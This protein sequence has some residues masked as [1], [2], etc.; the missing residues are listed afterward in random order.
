MNNT[1]L[2]ICNLL[3][4]EKRQSELYVG[5]TK[6][7]WEY[8]IVPFTA[9]CTEALPLTLMDKTIC[10][11]LDLDG[12]TTFTRLGT[13]LGLNVE[14]APERGEYRDAAEVSLLDNAVK[15]LMEYNMVERDFTY[16]S[17]N[18][19]ISLTEIGMEYYH[20]GKKFRTSSAKTF[21]VYFDR[22]S[23]AHAKAKD[24]FLTVMGRPDRSIVPASFKEEKFLKT[25]IHEQLPAIYDPEKGNSFTN[26]SCPP[27]AE[28]VKVPVDIGVLYDVLTREYRYVAILDEKVN[29]TL[30]EII[31][32]N[33]QI[34]QE[35][36]IQMR[37]Q[38]KGTTQPDIPV[39]EDFETSVRETS[40]V[41][42]TGHSITK[43][44]PRVMETEEFWQGLGLLVGEKEESVFLRVE[45]IGAAKCRAILNLCEKRPSTN[46]FLSFKECS[47]EIPFKANLYYV[48]QDIEGDFLLC[49]PSVTYALRGYTIHR[50]D[51]DV[52]KD[53]VFRYPDTDIDTDRIRGLFAVKLLPKMYADT[54]AFLDRDFEIKKKTV[55]MISH[56]DC[57]INVLKDFLGEGPLEALRAKKQEVF[58]RV[59]LAYEKTLVDKL[60]ALAAEKDLEYID[61]VK[62][63]EEISAKVDGILK[64]TDE[65]YITLQEKGRAFKQALKK[66]ERTIKDEKLAKT[67]IIDTNVFLEDPDILSKIRKPNRVV[68]SGQVLQELDKI[69]NKTDDPALAANA[70]KAV[71]AINAIKGKDKKFMVLDWAD[72]SLLPE[73][74]RTRKGDNY[75][76]GVAMK[77]RDNNP[78]IITSDNIF[79]L[80]ADSL[81]IPT[82]SLAEFYKKNGQEA[83]AAVEERKTLVHRPSLKTYMDVYRD[84]FEKKRRVRLP[85]FERNCINAGIRPQDLGYES[86]SD[87]IKGSSELTLYTTQ[88]GVIYVNLK[89]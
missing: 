6:Y 55:W 63:L 36:E 76:L 32:S 88:N 68:L 80:T 48:Q 50:G 52:F 83:P 59:K 87:L 30:S 39:Q 56:C 71:G 41:V 77:Y 19:A 73:E 65:T 72:M 16:G 26:L 70:R 44:I 62:E 17:A 33:A 57:R 1:S 49:T 42:E 35:L 53:M 21:K 2:Q 82:V 40:G 25:F 8:M 29:L 9:D 27:I 89:R 14:D 85:W 86:F 24:I 37:T 43:N 4:K 54:M 67:Y 5:F 47:E 78:W 12:K 51:T 79:A 66:R 75:I 69:K 31:A 28:T 61:K 58:N 46:V 15:G 7:N 38:L 84:L 64:D 22:T 45:H 60:V 13:I 10:G 74:L 34:M 20:Q 11:I 3:R 23:G 18:P 81:G